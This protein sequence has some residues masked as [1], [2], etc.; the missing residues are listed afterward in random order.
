MSNELPQGWI[1]ATINEINLHKS[2]NITPSDFPE[3][4]FELFSVPIFP[5]G[6]P[7]NILG[8][9]IGSSKQVVSPGDVLLCKINPRINRVWTVGEKANLRQIASSEWI[10]IR[11][12]LICANYLKYAFSKKDFRELL[13][14]EV[15][16][17]GGSLTRAQ[18]KKVEKYTV[19]IAPLNEQIRIADKLDSML[20]KVDAAQARLERIPTL[21]KRFRQ[22]VLAAATSGELTEV[23]RKQFDR[24]DEWNLVS[25]ADIGELGRGKSKHR[26]RNDPQLYGGPYPFIQ[27]GAVAQS[28]GLITFHSQTYSEFGLSQ[29]KLWPAGTLCITIAANIADTAILT[30]PA[31]FPDSVV[32]FVADP[33]KCMPQFVKWS[34]DVISDHLESFAPATAQKNINLAVLNDVRFRCPELEEQ[35]EIVRRVE[36]LFTLA[37][38]VEKQYLETKKRIDRL[39][40]SLLAKA[41][42]GELVP[43]DPNDE[44]AAEL[45]KRIQAERNAQPPMKN[46]RKQQA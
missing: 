31:C 4:E 40:Q 42:R 2:Q 14:S 21:L 7:E 26:P 22:A 43:Q 3:E 13:C 16:G 34:I 8:K 35:T 1:E 6:K 19:P 24:T 29:S 27:T 15:A 44:P 39:T 37:D 38:T 20:A 25:L 30:Y 9:D 46:K 11:N 33:S 23:W 36:S 32:G 28:G 17:V 12:P 10:N 18:P 41:F 45:L 5:T